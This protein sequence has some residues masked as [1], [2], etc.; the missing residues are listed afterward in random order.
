MPNYDYR[1]NS[2]KHEQEHKQSV[3]ED[4]IKVC[5]LCKKET[6]ERLITGNQNFQ[7]KGNGWFKT[8]GRY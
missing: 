6:Y 3:K 1:C 2:C 4:K 8:S 7:L 5:P